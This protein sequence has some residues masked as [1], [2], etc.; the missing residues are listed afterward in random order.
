MIFLEG[1]TAKQVWTGSTNITL[2]GIF[3]HC[4]T[5]HWVDDAQIADK[6]LTYW[7][8]V[9]SDPAMNTQ[10]DVS[11]S[12]QADVKLTTLPNGTYTFFSPRDRP[13]KTGVTPQH[14]KNY[15]DLIDAAQEMVCMVLPFNLDN[16]FKTVYQEDKN[17]LRFLIFEKVSE[18]EAVN[19]TDQDLKITAGAILNTPVE[20]FAEEVSAA[21]TAD[22]GILYVHNKFFIIDALT[23]DP[24][25][26][27]G[28]ANFSAN[29]ITE[30]DENSLMIKGDKRVA[31]IYLTEFNRLF[32]HFWPRF[33]QKLHPGAT[34]IGFAKPLDETFKWHF[35]YFDQTK[36]D[37][38]RKDQF[39]RMKL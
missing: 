37:F 35:D 6:Y 4:N 16:I 32:I 38:K 1:N 25:V 7:K 20:N 15:A 8:S 30:N 22:A 11:Q 2:A 14:L 5:G 23:E 29:S 21:S 28:S 9:K 31:D 24:I 19:S 18:A 26:V 27:T 36:F 17:Y 3:G 10:G 33:L 34:N 39:S 13:K 12:I